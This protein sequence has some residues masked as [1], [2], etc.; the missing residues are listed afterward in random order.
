MG[1]TAKGRKFDSFSDSLVSFIDK[2]F[3]EPSQKEKNRQATLDMID[4]L[5]EDGYSEAEVQ[6]GLNDAEDMFIHNE[7]EEAKLRNQE[8]ALKLDNEMQATQELAAD[9]D[10]SL[11]VREADI[12][13][14]KAKE[15]L[16]TTG[17]KT[18]TPEV[19]Q[20]PI[21]DMISKSI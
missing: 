1:R 2:A 11:K 8:K 12:Q 16:K 13:N 4:G 17:G 5:L 9:I 19:S 20:G 21:Y 15:V 14:E 6:K 10:T 3:V 18:V 7:R